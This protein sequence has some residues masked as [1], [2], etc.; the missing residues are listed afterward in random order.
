MDNEV[1]GRPGV[2]D[3]R[4]PDVADSDATHAKNCSACP[5]AKAT[6]FCVDCQEYLCSDCTN[7]HQ[8]LGALRKHILLT[9]ENFPPGDPPTDTH[10]KADIIE[11]CQDHPKKEIEFYCVKHDALCCVACT[12]LN[13]EQFTKTY[14]P[15]IAEDFKNGTEYK[16]LNTDIDDSE[17]L[18]VKSIVDVDECLKAVETLNVGELEKLRQYKATI[19]EYLD[20]REQELQAEMQQLHTEDVALLQ[21]LQ[22]KLKTCQSVLNDMREK[23]KT[24]EKNSSELFVSAKRMCGQMTKLQA[25]LKEMTKTIGYRQYSTL[26]DPKIKNILQD[27]NGVAGVEL[28]SGNIRISHITYYCQ[29]PL[30][31]H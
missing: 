26:L 17:R 14:I 15:D 20:R 30:L 27:Q 23:L 9:G 2:V 24:H 5:D 16:S 3:Q 4:S 13:H 19:I 1:D 22:I 31:K 7:Y 29:F 18:I 12:V 6:S 8:R 21:E 10:D 28:I 25:S 11:K